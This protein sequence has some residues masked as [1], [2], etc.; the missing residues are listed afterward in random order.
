VE[1][2]PPDPPTAAASAQAARAAAAE[3]RDERV[4]LPSHDDALVRGL[5]DGIG[6]PVGRY[7]GVGSRRSWW[8][9]LRVVVALAVVFAVL[10]WVQKL[11]CRDTSNWNHQLQYTTLCYSDQIALYSAEGLDQGKRPYLDY[12]V[13]Y[14][15][16]IGGFMEVAGLVAKLS[17]PAHLEN[18][19]FTGDGQAATFFDV[20]TL[21]MAVAVVVAALCTARAAGPR[22]WD[23]A[24]V[25]AAPAVILFLGT[26]WDMAAV[27]FGSAGILA[28]ARRRHGLA[29]VLLGLGVATKMFPALFLLPLFVLCLRAARLRA[30][31]AT[32]VATVVT[33]AL[34]YLPVYVTANAF[35]EQGDTFVKIE[36]SSAWHALTTRGVGAF[37]SALAPHHDGGLNGAAR[38]FTLNI[39]RVADWGSLPLALEHVLHTQF[40]YQALNRATQIAFIVLF[41]AIAG[42]IVLAPR[43][44]RVG[45][46]LFLTVV[47]FLITNKVYSPQYALWLLPLVALA[48]PRWR[49]VLIW[50]ASE[51]LTLIATHLH[52]AYLSDGGTAGVT[53]GW[54]AGAVTLRDLVLVWLCALVVRDI[55][56]PRRDPVRASAPVDDP[57]GGVLDAA[58]DARWLHA[59]PPVAWPAPSGLR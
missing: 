58:P 12:P 53:R 27:A 36:G 4:V 50:Q 20:S 5:S 18:G 49:D 46:V 33:V 51:L 8:T 45:Q 13:E 37:F 9:P 44:P 1:P 24:I 35:R 30:W 38:F 2:D 39:E 47:A 48:R 28:W 21:F 16:L 43:R 55:L 29:G 57:A 54:L 34:I 19:V 3:G 26:N 42:L 52:L 22:P 25:A 15:V 31:C 23:G 10:G 59:S 56:R 41:L 7:A 11:P 40:Q 6:G 14:P 32:V 17:T